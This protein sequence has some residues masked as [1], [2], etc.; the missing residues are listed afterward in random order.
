V[1]IKTR[2]GYDTVVIEDWV[3]QLLEEQPEVIAIH[4]RTLTQ[5]YRGQADWDAIR[6]AAKLVRETATLVLGN[7]DLGTMSEVVQRVRETQVHGVLIGRGALGNPWI[8]RAKTWAR[9]QLAM[10]TTAAPP[11]DVSVGERCQVALEHARYFE[12]LADGVQFQAMRKHLGWY[13][14]GF[15]GAADMRTRL[16]TTTTSGDVAQVFAA[17]PVKLAVDRPLSWVC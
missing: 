16:F 13:C 8:F 12:S 4:G 17:L 15:P 9:Q 11:P 5:R 3:S 1:S 10:R 6:R 7:G 2:L 14:Y